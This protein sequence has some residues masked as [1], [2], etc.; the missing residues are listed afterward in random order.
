M[1][2]GVIGG[3]VGATLI[4]G[5]VVWFDRR[6][7]A[8]RAPPTTDTTGEIEQPVHYPLTIETPRLFL[9]LYSLFLYHHHAWN[10]SCNW[11]GRVYSTGPFGS[12]NYPKTEDLLLRNRHIGT[13]GHLYLS[14]LGY[15]GLPEV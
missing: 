3:V 9:S 6:R 7:R 4:S 5:L 13:T 14:E 10:E 12:N 8:R 1:E 11:H 15:S 2:R